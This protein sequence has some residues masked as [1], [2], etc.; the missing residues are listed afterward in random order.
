MPYVDPERFKRF[1]QF[2]NRH[3]RAFFAA[4]QRGFAERGPGVV[5]YR[6][7]DDRFE[8]TLPVLRFEYKT[9]AEIEAAQSA[10]RDDLIQGMLE[11][12]QPPNEAL[13]AATYPDNSYDVTRVILQAV[14]SGNPAGPG[15]SGTS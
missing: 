2:V 14:P 4:A 9:R 8:G 5:L 1:E 7:P 13:I 3:M 10:K 12:Y 6:A 15:T 11:R